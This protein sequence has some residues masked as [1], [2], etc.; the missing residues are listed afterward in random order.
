MGWKLG[1]SRGKKCKVCGKFFQS[2]GMGP[3]M[4]VHKVKRDK[5]AEAP[6]LLTKLME[7]SAQLNVALARL[8][9]EA[10]QVEDAIAT[11][12]RLQKAYGK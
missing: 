8:S 5:V 10:A 9:A 4:R 12:R 2:H 7:K 1:K 3:H 6:D 11:L